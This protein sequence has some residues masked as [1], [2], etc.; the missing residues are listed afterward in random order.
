MKKGEIFL[1]ACDVQVDV[2]PRKK[3]TVPENTEVKIIHG[4][5]NVAIVEVI[6]TGQRFTVKAEQLKTKGDT[7]AVREQSKLF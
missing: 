2:N 7:P 3:N 5:D 4:S 1:L 6:S